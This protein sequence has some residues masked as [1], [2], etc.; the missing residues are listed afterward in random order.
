MAEGLTEEQKALLGALEKFRV[1]TPEDLE[2]LLKNAAAEQKE[3]VIKE[4]KVRDPGK[5][6]R[7]SLFYGEKGK[8]EVNYRT[9]RYEV[10]CLIKKQMYSKDGLL[11]GIRRSLRGEAAAMAMRLGECASVGDILDTFNAAFGNTETPES[12]LKK[13]H[14]C[15][16]DKGEPVVQY[17]ARLEEYFSMAIELGALTRSQSIV[18]KTVFHEGLHVDLKLASMYKF[19]KVSDYNDFKTEVRKLEAD[20]STVA[21]KKTTCAAA[22]NTQPTEGSEMNEV[23]TLL[24]Q[25]QAKIDKIEKQ[26]EEIKVQSAQQQPEMTGNQNSGPQ[27]LTMRGFRGQRHFRGTLNRG[28]QHQGNGRGTY[29]PQRPVATNVF[30]PNLSTVRCYNCDQMGHFARDCTLN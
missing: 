29:R 21:A 17:A 30:R 15:T 4:E 13:F 3:V 27:R 23:K 11:L 1:S 10:N 2:N 19:E 18:L 28:A 22:A 24:H 16:Q 26:Q 25:L 20:L 14:G 12:I 8:G 9:W 7:I 6:P 5:Y